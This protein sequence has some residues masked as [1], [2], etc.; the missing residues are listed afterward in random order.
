MGHFLE[1]E[2]EARW[3]ESRH[4]FAFSEAKLAS[5]AVEADALAV[6]VASECQVIRRHLTYGSPVGQALAHDVRV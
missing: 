4:L 3:D 2:L 6:T 5:K 1:D